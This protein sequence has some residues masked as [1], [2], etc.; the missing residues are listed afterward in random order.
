MVEGVVAAEPVPAA[1]TAVRHALVFVPGMGD[2]WI[3]QSVAGVAA[4]IADALNHHAPS[5]ARLTVDPEVREETFGQGRQTSACTIVRL[6]DGAPTAAIDVYKL[7]GIR[8]LRGDHA[9][10]SFIRK[11]ALPALILWSYV[12]RAMKARRLQAKSV[13]ER[14]QFNY[15]VLILLLLSLYLFALLATATVTVLDAVNPG[16]LDVL[17][18]RVLSGWQAFVVVLTALG[19]WKSSFFSNLADGAVG[20]VAV[21]SYLD[22]GDRKQNLVGELTALLEHLA[23]KEEDVGYERVDVIAFSFGG[24]VALDA[25]FPA[26]TE[27]SPR[28]HRVH[29]LVTI[30]CPFDFVRAYWPRYF[31]RRV[32]LDNVPRQWLNVYMPLDILSSNFRNDTEVDA[33]PDVGIPTPATDGVRFPTN[34]VYRGEKRLEDMTLGDYVAFLGFRSHSI[35]WGRRHESEATVFAQVVTAMY[36]G[37]PVLS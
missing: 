11:A 6:D 7:D 17:P 14:R 9:E 21:T 22:H 18:E 34:I 32:V 31:S 23:E 15:A 25:F 2:R 29:T 36:T 3:D 8:T 26:G 5:R 30:G 13:R 37:D 28:F 1:V 19:L 4:R 33:P 24:I 12:P 10:S 35:Y 27:P 20:H 16:W